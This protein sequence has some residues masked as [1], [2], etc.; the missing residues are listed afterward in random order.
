M[1]N[2]RTTIRTYHRGYR[3][4]ITHLLP[5]H[6][7]I[8]RIRIRTTLPTTP[9]RDSN[10]RAY[11]VRSPPLTSDFP[12]LIPKATCTTLRTSTYLSHL[13]RVIHPVPVTLTLTTV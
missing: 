11:R 8:I 4:S 3:R 10:A 13:Y 6:K 5:S 7:P 2:Q 12:T 9:I 1:P